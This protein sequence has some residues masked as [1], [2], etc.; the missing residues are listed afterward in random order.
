LEKDLEP[1]S[2][3]VLAIDNYLSEPPAGADPNVTL[4]A[5]TE[6]NPSRKR[7][8]W[9]MQVKLWLSRIPQAKEP[10]ETKKVGD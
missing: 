1:N 7:P 4:K 2:V 9:L 5:L 3:I 10:S 6:I 8:K